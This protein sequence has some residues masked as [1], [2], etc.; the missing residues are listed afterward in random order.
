MCNNIEVKNLLLWLHLINERDDAIFYF[1]HV[2]TIQVVQDQV[3]FLFE[4]TN[5]KKRYR[6]GINDHILNG[7][8]H[9]YIPAEGQKIT[10]IKGMAYEA[11][12]TFS[13]YFAFSC[14]KCN[15][16]VKRN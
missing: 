4:Q 2:F 11:V 5:E 8:I 1:L 14:Y 15:A 6:E 9:Q 16:A 3:L 10:G 12:Q 13:F 7:S